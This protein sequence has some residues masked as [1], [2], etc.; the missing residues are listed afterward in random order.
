MN[1]SKN[2]TTL[3]EGN[4]PSSL[5]NT[6]LDELFPLEDC[7]HW[8]K[9]NDKYKPGEWDEMTEDHALA[10]LRRLREREERPT[11]PAGWHEYHDYMADM[12]K[13]ALEVPRAEPSEAYRKSKDEF[14]NSPEMAEAKRELDSTK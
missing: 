10:A 14:M 4:R 8:N 2:P 9:D 1:T 7:M 13:Q 11:L 3:P 6:D 5:T 12:E